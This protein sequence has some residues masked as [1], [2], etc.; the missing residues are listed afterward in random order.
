M[1]IHMH[2]ITTAMRNKNPNSEQAGM[3][4]VAGESHQ[5]TLTV[6]VN[7]HKL[8]IRTV[9]VFGCYRA[10]VPRALTRMRTVAL[11]QDTC[12]CMQ[13]QTPVSQ[14]RKALSASSLGSCS[15]CLGNPSHRIAPT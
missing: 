6:D 7:R 8:L 14:L 1:Q 15:S 13:A 12:T 10:T 2:L 4:D 5:L 3:R 11:Q 9:T